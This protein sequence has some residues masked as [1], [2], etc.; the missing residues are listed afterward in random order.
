[1]KRLSFSA[2]SAIV[3]HRSQNLSSKDSLYNIV[4]GLVEGDSAFFA[5]FAVVRFKY[6]SVD[7]IS[8]FFDLAMKSLDLI[9][10][11]LWSSL[12]A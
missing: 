12:K 8:K 2:I 6:L 11:S 7:R 4:A 1:L 3:H 5:L 10:R 9:D